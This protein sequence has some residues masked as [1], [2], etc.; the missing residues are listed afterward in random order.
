MPNARSRGRLPPPRGLVTSPQENPRMVVDTLW[1]SGYSSPSRAL[2]L[3]GAATCS[4]AETHPALLGRVSFKRQPSGA[5]QLDWRGL[6]PLSTKW[7]LGPVRPPGGSCADSS[8]LRGRISSIAATE[9][10]SA[11]RSVVVFSS[12]ASSLRMMPSATAQAAAV[13]VNAPSAGGPLDGTLPVRAFVHSG[14]V[15]SLSPSLLSRYATGPVVDVLM[16]IISSKLLSISFESSMVFRVPAAVMKIALT[17]ASLN[18]RRSSGFLLIFLSRVIK[19]Q[20]LPFAPI[21][22][23]ISVSSMPKGISRISG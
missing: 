6:P 8:R 2:T 3:L 23:K 20:F 10:A 4:A 19:S 5:D 17:L 9:L 15:H 11:D 14:I 13:A 12:R 7:S 21:I 18:L 16:S 1:L 22:S